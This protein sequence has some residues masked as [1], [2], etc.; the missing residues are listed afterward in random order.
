MMTGARTAMFFADGREQASGVATVVETVAACARREGWRT[1]LVQYGGNDSRRAAR[2]VGPVIEV[3]AD[4]PAV[5]SVGRMAALVRMGRGDVVVCD[6]TRISRLTAYVCALSGARPIVALHSDNAPDYASA[7]ELARAFHGVPVVAVSAA[8]A[9]EFARLLSARGA[10][11]EVVPTGVAIGGSFA[12]QRDTGPARL[13]YVGRLTETAKRVSRLVPV[14]KRCAAAGLDVTL[15]VIGDGPARGAL[16]AAVREAGLAARI[17][18]LGHLDRDALLSVLPG[19]TALLLVSDFEGLPV[20][21]VEAMACGVVPIVGAIRS[22]VSELVQTGENG[23]V[24]DPP[25]DADGY[26]RAVTAL[27]R[28]AAMAARL[29]AAA[30]HTIEARYSVEAMWK[31]WRRALDAAGGTHFRPTRLPAREAI[32]SLLA[33]IWAHACRVAG[34]RKNGAEWLRE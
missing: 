17:R 33:K 11:V 19:Y 21:V 10:S 9:A 28:D 18:L 15:D 16:E 4:E 26:A 22:G 34:R 7:G 5:R 13:V 2:W 1:A 31:G 8:I 27:T 12:V 32:A 3:R 30:R 25:S 23:F 29:G 20:S 6:A 24:V 14:V